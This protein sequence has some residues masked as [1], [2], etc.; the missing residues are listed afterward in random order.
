MSHPSYGFFKTNDNDTY[1]T[2][3]FSSLALRSCSDTSRH[4][5]PGPGALSKQV[6]VGRALY[7]AEE[8]SSLDFFTAKACS[9][10]IPPAPQPIRHTEAPE[11]VLVDAPLFL[12]R[13]N[14]VRIV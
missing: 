13:E 1:A 14:I 2:T 3:K 4:I 10:L 8:E 6:I 7:S 5:P 11:A 9:R 12:D